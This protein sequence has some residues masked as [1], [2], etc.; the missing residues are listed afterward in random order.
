MQLFKVLC[1]RRKKISSCY[2]SLFTSLPHFLLLFYPL[3]NEPQ[4]F[5]PENFFPSYNTTFEINTGSNCMAWKKNRMG[6]KESI[7]HKE[8]KQVYEL[9][10]AGWFLLFLIPLFR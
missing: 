10:K 9:D 8:T 5:S 4:N 2:N 3:F 7:Y 6:L 1:H